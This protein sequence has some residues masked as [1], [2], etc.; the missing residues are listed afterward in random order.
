MM[1]IR[2]NLIFAAAALSLSAC[3]SIQSW[4]P[5]KEKDYQFATEIPPMEVP[6]NLKGGNL[7]K[8]LEEAPLMRVKRAKPVVVPEPVAHD[9]EP[10]EKVPETAEAV[11]AE[12][13]APEA[14][15]E[16]SAQAEQ[17]EPSEQPAQTE[18]EQSA[19]AAEQGQAEQAPEQ[20][21]EQQPAEQAETPSEDPAA[22]TPVEL[23]HYADGE[24]R[25]RIQKTPEFAWHL[26]SKALSRNA[27][28]VTERDQDQKL[29]HVLY[30]PEV[31][32]AE[33]G[34]LLDE[35]LFFLKGIETNEK[36][37]LLKLIAVDGNSDLAVMDEDL[38]PVVNDAVAIKLLKLLG[39]T[40]QS[41]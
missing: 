35:A 14:A 32:K 25:L 38:N 18:T 26:V 9:S 30:N 29:F 19:P 12:T 8:A 11:E 40:I 33:D 31:K 27:I 16:Q 10:S 24:R 17:T 5:D 28:E 20:S 3:S 22:P 1:K 37:Y 2:G 34:S 36:R 13:T 23:V 6:G 21:A 15:A 39:G 7:A 4:F 41:K